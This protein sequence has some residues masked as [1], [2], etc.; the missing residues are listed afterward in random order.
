MITVFETGTY[1]EAC[2]ASPAVQEQANSNSKCLTD[3]GIWPTLILSMSAL[4]PR[5]ITF[6]VGRRQVF[7]SWWYLAKAGT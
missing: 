1:I 3:S 5:E 6:S 2:I 4:S 7:D